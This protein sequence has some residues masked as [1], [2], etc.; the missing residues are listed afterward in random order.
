MKDVTTTL[1]DQTLSHISQQQV[2]LAILRINT[3]RELTME[4]KVKQMNRQ[5]L[6]NQA[7]SKG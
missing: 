6:I 7:M 3:F 5:T 1:R 2:N 4:E